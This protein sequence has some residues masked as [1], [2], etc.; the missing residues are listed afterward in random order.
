MPSSDIDK[1]GVWDSFPE[2]RSA[3]HGIRWFFL[4]RRDGQDRVRPRVMIALGFAGLAAWAV[5]DRG[6]AGVFGIAVALVAVAVWHLL[7][8]ASLRFVARGPQDEAPVV[9]AG[10]LA[11]P[12]T[13]LRPAPWLP[14][15]GTLDPS[16]LAALNVGQRIETI[17]VDPDDERTLIRAPD[18]RPF[19]LSLV[20]FH[21][22]I[23][24]VSRSGKS[25]WS[26]A[27]LAA[28]GPYVG[29]GYA[30]VH[31]IDPKGGVEVGLAE[32]LFASFVYGDKPNQWA[33]KAAATLAA[34]QGRMY[35][36]L[37]EMR[38]AKVRHHTIRVGDPLIVVWIDELGS[39]VRLEKKER[40]AILIPLTD[41]ME[42]GAAADVVVVAAIQDPRKETVVPNRDLYT[43][44]IGLR[45]P[46]GM[47]PVVFN[48]EAR[49][50]GVWCDRIHPTL[51]RGV[52]FIQE[53]GLV[54]K[55]KSYWY[56][57]GEVMRLADDFHPRNS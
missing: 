28:V 56:S 40:D 37:A 35:E 46:T 50:V 12:R 8:P 1:P 31:A 18:G 20:D 22:L 14:P 4:G 25:G 5:L 43:Q 13:L 41:V 10:E 3:G 36:R 24:G 44:S 6:P 34:I 52:G 21:T 30:E 9:I 47:I 54:V 53:P 11:M 16:G 15:G 27:T 42:K 7:S 49:A 19:L 51:E 26:W 23:A 55:A 45:L 57:D 2:A 39:I 48:A 38:K 17:T 33:P 32:G 29:C